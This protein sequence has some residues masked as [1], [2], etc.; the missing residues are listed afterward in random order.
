MAFSSSTKISASRSKAPRVPVRGALLMS[1]IVSEQLVR[2]QSK[3]LNTSVALA[4]CVLLSACVSLGGSPSR[5]D[6]QNAFGFSPLGVAPQ[7]SLQDENA[8]V[9][10]QALDV[11][12]PVFN[13]LLN[14]KSV[15]SSGPLADVAA[16]V[17]DANSRTAEAELRAARLRSEAEQKNWLPRIGP[18]ISLSSLG[19]AVAGLV[20][21]QSLFDNGR[22]AAERE[23]ARAD[24]QV[25]AVALAEDSNERVRQ[26][27]E[28]YLKAEAARARAAVNAASISKMEHFE[29]VMNERVRGGVSNRADLL[30]VQ[31]KRNQMDSDLAA[32][33]EAARTARAELDAMSAV[34]TSGITGLSA[35]TASSANAVPLSVLRA[36]AEAARSVANAKAQRGGILPGVNLTASVTNRGN[37][38]GVGSSSQGI[39]FG[40]GASLAALDAKAEAAAAKV[41]QDREAANRRIASLD[42]QIASIL[43][44]AG[45]AKEIAAQAARNYDLFAQQLEAGQRGVP[46]VVSVFETKVRAEREAVNLVYE[47]ARLQIERAALLGTL[48]DGGRI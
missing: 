48:V 21:E 33:R 37:D 45:E 16:S 35:V 8:L 39:G 19:G 9:A 28:L 31:Q 26:A 15:L 27:L 34:P 29:Y 18:N 13:D 41:V 36:E 47:L 7:T 23:L 2:R 40:T 11:D 10:A 4:S 20:V 17:L 38:V 46:E 6:G 14:R 25:A 3:H 24:V 42:G 5:I 32:D 30:L 1:A 44:Q 12:A 22:K 43:R